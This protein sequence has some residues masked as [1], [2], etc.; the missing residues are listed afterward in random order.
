MSAPACLGVGRARLS[1]L[2]ASDRLAAA[3][4]A[5]ALMNER[6]HASFED[7][8][9]VAPSVLRHRIILDYNARVEGLTSD[10]VISTL[11]E[12][13]PFQAGKNPKTLQRSV[14]T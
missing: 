5:C 11:L 1:G 3:A 14:S 2:L 12:E 8:R 10:E 13:V 7:V 6:T 9:F 4:R